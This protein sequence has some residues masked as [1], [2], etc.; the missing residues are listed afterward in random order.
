MSDYY[1]IISCSGILSDFR[2][3][4]IWWDTVDELQIKV[5]IFDNSITIAV[6]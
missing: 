1:R 4:E 6:I 5:L 2:G 3:R